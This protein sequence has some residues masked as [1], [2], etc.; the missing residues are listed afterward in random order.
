MQQDNYARDDACL[1]TMELAKSKNL[2]IEC[3]LP[4]TRYVK[5]LLGLET[6]LVS[7]AAT[8]LSLLIAVEENITLVLDEL[9][10]VVGIPEG[11]E[12]GSIG[13]SVV[14]ADKLLEVL[15]SLG[16]VVEGHLG[17]EVV[18]DVVVGDVVEEE[19]SLPA[20]E[21]T[22]DGSGGTTLEGPFLLAVV[23][24]HGVGV[25]EVGD[26]DEPVADAEPGETVVFD[27]FASSVDG[28]GVG[29]TPDHGEDA[30]VGSEDCVALRRVEDHRV[31]CMR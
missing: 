10:E 20:E 8:S 6:V 19:T 4:V 24:E 5:Y 17:E 21:V 26:H 31:G 15:S 23:G 3:E 12:H 18:D 13:V 11:L 7:R 28:R 30:G 22:V 14:L 1:Y 29:D 9:A 25:V 16:S 2:C 27:D